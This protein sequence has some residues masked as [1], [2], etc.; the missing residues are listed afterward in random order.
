MKLI[1]SEISKITNWGCIFKGCLVKCTSC[2]RFLYVCSD[3]DLPLGRVSLLSLCLQPLNNRELQQIVSVVIVSKYIAAN[4]LILSNTVT[5]T[6]NIHDTV[7]LLDYDY[8]WL[9]TFWLNKYIWVRVLL[10]HTYKLCVE[11]QRHT[12]LI[13][14]K[15]PFLLQ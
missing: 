14:W 9:N 2:D 8:I 12:G 13:F 5:D 7:W 10:Y 1:W 4:W 3:V 15:F 6:C 11:K